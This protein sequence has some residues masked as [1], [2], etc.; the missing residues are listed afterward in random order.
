MP[1]LAMLLLILAVAVIAPPLWGEE[2]RELHPTRAYQG[3][4]WQDPL[5]TDALG[6]DILLRLLVAT[7]LSIELALGSAGLGLV[8]G[9]LIG[10]T[11]ALLGG[12]ARRAVLRVVDT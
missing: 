5:G 9:M 6:R 3:P 12:R 7:R 10:G 1:A 4:S 2:A 11:A 8:L